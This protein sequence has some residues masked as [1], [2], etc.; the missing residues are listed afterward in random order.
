MCKIM[1]KQDQ[2]KERIL[3]ACKMI[4][5]ARPGAINI[6][7]E[8][9]ISNIRA[10][11][12]NSRSIKDPNPLM[13][14]MTNINV[15]FPITFKSDRINTELIPIELFSKVSDNRRSGRV[16]CK[17]EMIHW[18]IDNVDENT[19]K[20]PSIIKLFEASSNKFKK[21]FDY[22]WEGVSFKI[23]NVSLSRALVPVNPNNI[24]MPREF[25]KPAILRTLNLDNM[26]EYVDVP[27][28]YLN[29][30]KKIL[31]DSNLDIR[32]LPNI[33]NYIISQMDK[34]FRYLPILRGLS[35]DF[36]YI[37]HALLQPQYRSSALLSES[38]V[39]KGQ[40][41][42]ITELCINILY[43]FRINSIP[44]Y[45]I[46]EVV[47]TFT[48][49]GYP[50]SKILHSTDENKFT[51]FIKGCMGIEIVPVIEKPS[52]KFYPKHSSLFE[53]IHMNKAGVEFRRYN[54]EEVVFFESSTSKGFFVHNADA[55]LTIT[56]N[57]TNMNVYKIIK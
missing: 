17:T 31:E 27:D 49:H 7:R 53:T 57:R 37:S 21:V 9:T 34:K 45:Q 3:W 55:L 25:I 11:E 2:T 23:G 13:S 15:K 1:N 16:L 20:V 54:G 42:S 6:L 46:R 39:E 18:Y 8:G 48:F 12:R 26:I 41:K 4:N 22:P 44:Y 40:N 5:R 28:Y 35:P 52:I 47:N 14:T 29:Q 43:H 56:I 50:V 33:L 30:V 36:I 32:S 24:D 51:R 38:S 10:I 19:E